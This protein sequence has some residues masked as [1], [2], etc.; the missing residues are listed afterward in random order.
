MDPSIVKGT[1][2]DLFYDNPILNEIISKQKLNVQKMI[3]KYLEPFVPYPLFYHCNSQDHNA[4]QLFVNEENDSQGY[5]GAEKKTRYR[6]ALLQH[7]NSNKD[8]KELIN[9]L[10]NANS[11]A[12]ANSNS[13]LDFS[14][15]H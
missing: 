14:I 5:G 6:N 12:K 2:T 8:S 15:E 3:R 13:S 4:T 10:S 11:S 7:Y 9:S 1:Q